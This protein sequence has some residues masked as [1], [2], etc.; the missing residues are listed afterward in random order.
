MLI[1]CRHGI[2]WRVEKKEEGFDVCE[3]YHPRFIRTKKRGVKNDGASQ[4]DSPSSNRPSRSTQ[5]EKLAAS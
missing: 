2:L 3:L 4:Q 5:A 1:R